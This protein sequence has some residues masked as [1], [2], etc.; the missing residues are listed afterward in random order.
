V[1]LNQSVNR[2]ANRMGRHNMIEG[3]H[4][5]LGFLLGLA[6]LFVLGQGPESIIL[7]LLIAAIIC[8]GIDI[9]RLVAPFRAATGGFQRQELHQLLD[10]AWPLVAAQATEI[11][12]QN[13]DRFLLGSLN[14]TEALGIFAVAYSLVERPTSLIC[15]SITTATFPL[16]LQVLERQGKEA[17]RL[18]AGR[19]GIAL[20]AVALPACAGLALTASY[21]SAVLVGPAFR[22]GVAALIPIMCFATLIRGVRAHFVDHA[23]H[24][25]GKPLSMLWSYGPATALNVLL[26]LWAVPHYGMFGAAWVSVICQIV[27]FCGSWYLANRQ[28]PVWLPAGQVVRCVLAIVP[29]AA[30]LILVRFPLD[31]RGLLAA[32]LMGGAVYAASAIAL[33]VGEVRSLGWSIL[34]RRGRKVPVLAG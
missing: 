4:A 20:L 10:Y 26:N 14:G 34:R 8:A 9:R 6:A 19:N 12:M 28:F 29:M 33:D 22:D 32:T 11:I 30:A 21:L 1:Q 15:L 18:Q 31:W 7:G 2:S 24:L 13:G 25:S 3:L 5:T 23:F 27:A 16:V 17:A